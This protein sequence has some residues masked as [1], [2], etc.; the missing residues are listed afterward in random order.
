MPPR[1]AIVDLIFRVWSPIYDSALFQK[2]FYRRIHAA[3]LDSLDGPPPRRVLDLGCGTAQLTA[4]LRARFPHALVLGADLSG[5]MLAAAR[6]R[7][8]AATPPLVQA[9]VYALPFKDGSLDLVTS[10]VSYHWYLEPERALAEIH[11]VLE[12]GGRFQLATMTHTWLWRLAPKTRVVGATETRRELVA[13]GFQVTRETRLR[14][15]VTLYEL[16]R[17]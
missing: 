6:R 9:N 15:W 11:R 16:I 7:L 17:V 10:T 4:D 3:V 8:G 5:D 14:P 13:G 2:P 1:D 12:P